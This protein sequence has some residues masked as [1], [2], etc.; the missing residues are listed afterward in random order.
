VTDV[1][2]T[3]GEGAPLV[4]VWL[5]AVV[6]VVDEEDPAAGVFD[7]HEAARS[8]TTTAGITIR[9]IRARPVS[10]RRTMLEIRRFLLA[11]MA[12]LRLRC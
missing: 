11:S 3:P 12:P 10:V 2:V 4:V 8:A 7:E 9:P 5:E 1:A 6:V